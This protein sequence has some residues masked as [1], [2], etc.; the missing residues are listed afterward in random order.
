MSDNHQAEL[1][2]QIGKVYSNQFSKDLP[3]ANVFCSWAY[4][5]E[6]GKIIDGVSVN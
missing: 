1:T 3:H 2:I 6:Y 5:N 4:L